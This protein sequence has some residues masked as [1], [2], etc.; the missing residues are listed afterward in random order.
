LD[1]LQFTN[2]A[3]CKP[4]DSEEI[5]P[6]KL[7][8]DNRIPLHSAN[9]FWIECILVLILIRLWLVNLSNINLEKSAIDLTRQG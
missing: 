8:S 2:L 4:A 9:A 3:F 7:A 1:L 6:E 5:P